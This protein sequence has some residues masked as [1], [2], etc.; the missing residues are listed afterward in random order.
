MTSILTKSQ[1]KT[2]GPKFYTENGTTY[3]LTATVRY[4][5]SCGNG[6]N[7]FA[8]TGAQYY[9]EG[10]GFWREDA[11][12]CL[13]DII[14]KQ[15]PELAPFIKWHLTSSDGPWGYI[16]NTVYFAGDR[17]HWGLQKD[18]RRQIKNG[19]TGKPAWELVARHKTIGEILPIY[20]LDKN[21]D[22]DTM[23]ACEYELIW[24]SWDRVGEGKE[25]EL[26]KARNA[27]VWP[28]ATDEDLIAPGLKERLEARL[29]QLMQEFKTA[30]E[31]LGFVY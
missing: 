4:D 25:R 7:S 3:K 5:D 24:K 12:G 29:P 23:P 6:H 22:A 9:K 20:K 31:S 10:R 15:F 28:D 30:V 1:V 13:H 11:F 18:E 27:A 16:A 2:Y 19:K 26:D 14:A 8:I 17:D 21:I